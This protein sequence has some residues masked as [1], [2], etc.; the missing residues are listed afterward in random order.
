MIHASRWPKLDVSENHQIEH[1]LA[2]STKRGIK[3]ET[4]HQHLSTTSWRLDTHHLQ[5]ENSQLQTIKSPPEWGPKPTFHSGISPIDFCSTKITKASEGL[6]KEIIFCFFALI[7]YFLI[8]HGVL[9][10]ITEC[11][12][13]FLHPSSVYSY[14][15]VCYRWAWVFDPNFPSTFLTSRVLINLLLPKKQH[16][17]KHNAS[18]SL[19]IFCHLQY[20]SLQLCVYV[21][22]CLDWFFAHQKL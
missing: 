11:V 2:H 7:L 5:S 22:V 16:S 10:H 3:L 19:H 12:C 8:T 4:L 17:L 21:F 18:T 13:I 9:K 20:I 15:M 1:L 14:H 6:R